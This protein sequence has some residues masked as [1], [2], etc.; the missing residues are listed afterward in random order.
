MKKGAKM[1]GKVAK[2]NLKEARRAHPEGSILTI[3]TTKIGKD[4]LGKAI[5]AESAFY[6]GQRR[7]YQDLK[8]VY[9]E[10]RRQ[11]A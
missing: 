10:R 1:R 7:V 4:A 6:T 8:N 9:K 5:Y 11:N 2:R 3:K